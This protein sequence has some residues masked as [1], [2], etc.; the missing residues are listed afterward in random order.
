MESYVPENLNETKVSRAGAGYAQVWIWIRIPM[1]ESKVRKPLEAPLVAKEELPL[2]KDALKMILVS[3]SKTQKST[4]VVT[5][6]RKA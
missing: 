1:T 5:G 4:F 3:D 6:L 2:C